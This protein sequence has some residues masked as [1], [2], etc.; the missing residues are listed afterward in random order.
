MAVRREVGVLQCFGIGSSVCVALY[1]PTS[2]VAGMCHAMLAHQ[3]DGE[4]NP[5]KA[6]ETAIPALLEAMAADGAEVS[7]I[8]AWI[9]GGANLLGSDFGSAALEVV[10]DMLKSANVPVMGREVG[11][12]VTRSVRLDTATG[13]WSLERLAGV[14]MREAA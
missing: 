1:D 4:A 14:P 5:F 7:S 12:N 8:C 9:A 6:A 13:R 10:E 11:G 2:R 3:V